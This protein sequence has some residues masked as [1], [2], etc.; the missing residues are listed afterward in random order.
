MDS[1]NEQP[2]L[3][4][5]AVRAQNLT[6]RYQPV[7]GGEITALSDVSFEASIGQWLALMGPSGSGKSSLLHILG[8]LLSVDS[9]SL[10]VSGHT[11]NNYGPAALVNYRRTVTGF[12]FQTFHL[13]PHLEAWENVSLPLIAVGT[14]PK[15]RRNRAFE[16]L[17]SVGLESRAHHRPDELSG[18][19]RQRVAL[20]R[21]VVHRPKLVLADEPTGN[22]DADSA[23]LVLNILGQFAQSG[24][25]VISATHDAAVASR[26]DHIM[27]LQYGKVVTS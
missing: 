22:L 9:G 12:V 18:G 10:W 13:L 1:L 7:A 11:I 4:P 6:V 24:A 23:Q 26:A 2:N 25:C 8:G 19:E 14:P 15:V 20:A 27:R 17:A 5:T 21:A 3:A 16:A